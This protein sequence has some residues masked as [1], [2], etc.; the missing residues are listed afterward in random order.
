MNVKAQFFF[1]QHFEAIIWITVLVYF[2]FTPVVSD[3][4]F[5]I[6]PLKLAGFNYC[7]GCGLGRSLML[8]LHGRISESIQMHPLGIPALAILIWRIASVI[9]VAKKF[10]KVTGN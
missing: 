10:R 1:L 4:H 8:L 7:P 9:M 6:C 5:T 2:A 3:A